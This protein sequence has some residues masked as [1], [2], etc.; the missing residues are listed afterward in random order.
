MTGRAPGTDVD[1]SA[2]T[3][4]YAVP[5]RRWL[6]VNMV[7]TLDGAATG[8]SGQTG[9]INN[10]ADRRVFH[11]LRSMADAVLVGA[12][13]ARTEGYGP[14]VVPVVLVSRSADVPLR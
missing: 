12:G 13:T 14:A 11:L 3:E 4:V 9:S 7:S 10:E 6:R 1:D 8:D 5:Q 2:L